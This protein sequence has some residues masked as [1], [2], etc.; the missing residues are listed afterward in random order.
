MA[1]A[2]ALRSADI[3]MIGMDAS[4][5]SD[6][7][8]TRNSQPFMIGIIRSSRTTSGGAEVRNSRKASRPFEASLTTSPSSRSR[9]V[10]ALRMLMSSSTTGGWFPEAGGGPSCR[11]GS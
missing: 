1:R 5:A 2:L 9:S 8:S 3:A 4:I 6:R 11:L 10:S 7:C